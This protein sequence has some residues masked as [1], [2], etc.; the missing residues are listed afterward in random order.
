MWTCEVLADRW[1]GQKMAI[2]PDTAARLLHRHRSAHSAT[3]Q[4]RFEPWKLLLTRVLKVLVFC[5]RAAPFVWRKH[6]LLNCNILQN[7]TR[8]QQIYLK[9][10]KWWL[11]IWIYPWIKTSKLWWD[12]HQ[13]LDL[14]NLGINAIENWRRWMRNLFGNY[15]SHIDWSDSHDF[16][17]H[18]VSQPGHQRNKS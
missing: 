11:S 6:T 17:N 5:S 2:G 16:E 13:E 15:W 4:Q 12:A 14:R 9:N 1:R 7:K 3:M 10:V 8:S 18:V